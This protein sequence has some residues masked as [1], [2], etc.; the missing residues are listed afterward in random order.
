M[1]SI[2]KMPKLGL[3]MKAGIIVRWHKK[4]GDWVVKGDPLFEIETDKISNEYQSPEEGYLLK[5]LVGENEEVPVLTPVCI[6]GEK[7]DKVIVP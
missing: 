6:I 4:E 1:G 2:I 7:D 3:T 5:I